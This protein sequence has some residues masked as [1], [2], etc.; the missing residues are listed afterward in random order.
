LRSA[1]GRSPAGVAIGVA[2]AA[3]VHAEQ[4]VG[5]VPLTGSKQPVTVGPSLTV[6][7]ICVPVQHPPPQQVEP[8]LQAAPTSVHGQIV[9]QVPFAQYGCAP[10]QVLPHIPQLRMSLPAFTQTPAQHLKP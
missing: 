9:W 2:G 10:P 3:Q 6:Q 1:I 7:Q 4:P 8:V 5:H